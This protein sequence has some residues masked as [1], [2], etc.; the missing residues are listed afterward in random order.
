MKSRL[1]W[2]DTEIM[3][4]IRRYHEKLDVDWGLDEIEKRVRALELFASSRIYQ[5]VGG[6]PIEQVDAQVQKLYSFWKG[7]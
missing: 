5:R 7:K 1:D 6:I 2:S 4:E 3:R